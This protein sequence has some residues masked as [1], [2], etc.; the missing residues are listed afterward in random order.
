VIVKDAGDAA[1]GAGNGLAVNQRQDL[2]H[3]LGIQGIAIISDLK[4]KK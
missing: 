2:D 3:V 4:G 1:L